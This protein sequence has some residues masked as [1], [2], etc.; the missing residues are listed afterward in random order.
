[1]DFNVEAFEE[2]YRTQGRRMKSIAFNM[3]GSVADAED[4]VQ[5][6]FLRAYRSWPEFRGQASLST[7][8]FRILFNACYDIGRLRQKRREDG[9]VDDPAAELPAPSH[10]H[11][12]RATLEKAI[13]RLKPRQ[14]EVFLL[15]E[16]E[17]FKHGEIAEILQIPEG[18]SKATLFEA[19]RELRALI[20]V[21]APPG[22]AS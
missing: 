14:R 4:A 1:L 6:A 17:G 9:W 8:A 3:L 18:T 13:G 21:A 12:L 22:A 20:T 7:W 19:K 10:D 16:V 5:E 2:L 11:P 15:Y